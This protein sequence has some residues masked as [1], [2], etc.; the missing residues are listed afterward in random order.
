M[1]VQSYMDAVTVAALAA[2]TIA[3]ESF[4]FEK[5]KKKVLCDMVLKF[6]FQICPA[7]SFK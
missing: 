3:V 2:L 1:F 7:S 4:R 5:S 6:K